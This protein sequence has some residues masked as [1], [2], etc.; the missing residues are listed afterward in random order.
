MGRMTAMQRLASFLIETATRIEPDLAKQRKSVTVP[1]PF[2]RRE[3]ADLLGLTI[4]TVSRQFTGLRKS[5]T[6]KILDR[7]LVMICDWAALQASVDGW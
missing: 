3:I 4:E 6:I 5:G 7:R 1:L 2:N